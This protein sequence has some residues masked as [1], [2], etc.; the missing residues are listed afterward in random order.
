[1]IN[2]LIVDDSETETKILKFL[3]ESESDIKIIGTAKNGKEAIALLSS[4]KPDLITMDIQMPLMDGFETSRYIMQHHPIPIVV[5]SAFAKNKELNTVYNAL[6]AGAL[7]VIEKPTNI[8]APNFEYT[9]KQIV[10]TIRAM[11]EIK[12]VKRRFTTNLEHKNITS[13]AQPAI[14]AAHY[15]IIGIGTSVGGPQALKLI[16]SELPSD[17]PV[18]I[19]IVQHM[20]LGFISSFSHWLNEN[21]QL[22]IKE[23]EQGEI[24]AKSTVY[25]APD[26]YHLEIERS[27]SQLIAKLVSAKPVSG[28]CPSATVL[29]GSIA[30]TCGKQGIGIL[31]TGMGSD[32]AEGLLELKHAHGHTIIQDPKSAVVFGMAGVAQSL[33]AVDTIVELT[34]MANYLKQLFQH[35]I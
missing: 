11:A 30:R 4:L 1:M 16:L 15:E 24:L 14:T 35:P 20:A 13:I 21:T 10:S 9:R 2:I 25:F 29:L 19:V 7:C 26:L 32:G 28:F 31:L 33:G 8:T 6:A 5:V 27:H 18:P 17:F 3:F 23:A 34:H 12:V 22:K